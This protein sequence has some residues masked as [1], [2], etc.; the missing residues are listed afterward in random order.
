MVRS[1]FTMIELIFAIVVISIAVVSLPMMTQATDKGIASNIV[2]EAIF[3]TATITNASTSYYWDQSS[4]EDFAFANRAQVVNTGDCV[5]GPPNQRIGHINR[6]CLVDNT[7]TPFNGVDP[8]SLEWASSVYN[9][10][11]ILTGT[12]GKA[13][14]KNSYNM[15]VAV[16]N[17]KTAGTCT[18]FGNEA[19]NEDLK[20][21]EVSV[22][23]E[24][25]SEKLVVLKAYTANIG[26]PT[27]ASEF[28]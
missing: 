16:R 11:P 5:A 3:A 17:C 19:G 12:A 6:E 15:T 21:L 20:E 7:T 10:T 23:Q 4:L 25:S 28:L 14:Y 26:A 8:N 22:T 18:Q 13:T 1:A 24:G 2:Q 27:I 9:N